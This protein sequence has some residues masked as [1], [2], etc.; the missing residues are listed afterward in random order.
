[1]ATPLGKFMEAENGEFKA[2]W[3]RVM[4]VIMKS[5]LDTGFVYS[6]ERDKGDVP[7]IVGNSNVSIRPV[8]GVIGRKGILMVLWPCTWHY[9]SFAGEKET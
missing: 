8:I 4:K 1:L 5:G 3:R 2:L 6:D 7:H 9:K